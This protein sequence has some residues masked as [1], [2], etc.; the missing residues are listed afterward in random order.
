MSPATTEAITEVTS[1][2]PDYFPPPVAAA[3]RPHFSTLGTL[4][5]A[6][7]VEQGRRM[8]DGLHYSLPAPA[9]R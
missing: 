6:G 7:Q 3:D 2:P 1:F 5:L 4:D 8:S 9:T